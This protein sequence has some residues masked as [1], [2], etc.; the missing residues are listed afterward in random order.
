MKPNFPRKYLLIKALGCDFWGEVRHLLTQLLIADLLDRVPVVLWG[1]NF[2]YKKASELNSIDYFFPKIS[3]LTIDKL[4]QSMSLFPP[5]WNWINIYEES[6]NKWNCQ[7]SRIL[8]K[9]LFQRKEIFS[10]EKRMF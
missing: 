3:E 4:S 1:R 5:K 10:S 7:S 9:Y 6:S 2:R 8:I